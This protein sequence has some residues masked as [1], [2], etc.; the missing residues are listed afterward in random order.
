M[1]QDVAT[2]DPVNIEVYYEISKCVAHII[3]ADDD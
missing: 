3:V 1:S 2:S